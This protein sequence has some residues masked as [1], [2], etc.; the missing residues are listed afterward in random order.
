[1]QEFPREDLFPPS[2]Q[3]LAGSPGELLRHIRDFFDRLGMVGQTLS[4]EYE[5]NWYR[6]CCDENTF[7]VY[8]VNSDGGVRHHMPGWPVCL[9]NSVTI[10]EEH[11]LP[12]LGD[13]HCASGAD[14]CRWLEIIEHRRSSGTLRITVE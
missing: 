11:C 7:M 5:G 2:R 9:V 8:R 1:M 3:G 14:I 6:V 13:D 10:F 12:D 4:V